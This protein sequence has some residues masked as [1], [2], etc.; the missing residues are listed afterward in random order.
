MKQVGVSYPRQVE[1]RF[2]LWYGLK[3]T[4]GIRICVILPEYEKHRQRRFIGLWMGLG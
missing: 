4:Q 2:Q 1:S 3:F